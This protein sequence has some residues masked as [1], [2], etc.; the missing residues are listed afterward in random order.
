M[1]SWYNAATNETTVY[2]YFKGGNL[3]SIT[4]GDETVSFLYGINDQIVYLNDKILTYDNIGNPLNYRDLI[5][6]T[7]KNGRQM[8]TFKLGDTYVKK[9]YKKDC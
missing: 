5:R 1:T 2:E 9:I 8:A 6:L 7:W 3:A 4:K